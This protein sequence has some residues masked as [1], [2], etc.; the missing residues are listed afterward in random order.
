MFVFSVVLFLSMNILDLMFVEWNPW[1]QVDCL[2]Y[3]QN[4]YCFHLLL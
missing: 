2:I 1:V 4:C 3:E